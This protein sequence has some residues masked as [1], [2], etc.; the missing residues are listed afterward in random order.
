MDDAVQQQV[1]ILKALASEPRLQI[2][3]LLREHPQCVNVIAT[4]LD[5]TQ[6][7]VSQHLQL[8]KEVGLVRAEKRGVWMHYALDDVALERYGRAMADIFGGWVA[9][10][11]PVDGRHGCPP[12]LLH[13]C[14][15]VAP[16][17]DAAEGG[18]A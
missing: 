10:A 12:T 14:Q 7:A 15:T 4:R 18:E 6:P 17:P 1:R 2:M 9:V 8:L 11:E 13:Q 3:R 5:M 16:S